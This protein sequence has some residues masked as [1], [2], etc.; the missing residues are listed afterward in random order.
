MK[1]KYFFA[2]IF[3]IILLPVFV[4]ALDENYCDNAV[5]EEYYQKY[6]GKPISYNLKYALGIKGN[7]GIYKHEL[8]DY[9]AKTT[10]GGACNTPFYGQGRA[11]GDRVVVNMPTFLILINNRVLFDALVTEGGYG[12]L[13]DN[14]I[15][16]I[17]KDRGNDEYLTP[18][19]LAVREGQVGTLKYLI[20]KYQVNLF[21]LSGNLY[22][23]PRKPKDA[24]RD[25]K[26]LMEISMERYKEQ[27]NYAKIECMLAVQKVVDQWLKKN[28]NN[29]KYLDDAE[30]YNKIVKEWVP[31]NIVADVAPFEFVPGYSPSL[32][33]FKLQSIVEESFAQNIE[34]QIDALME[35]IMRDFDISALGNPA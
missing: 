15:Y 22:R 10:K 3:A 35:K 24:P 31:K 30:R 5:Y 14:G 12:Y 21:K 8:L 20:D 23:S 25:V 7:R 4:Y 28:A 34:K 11:V 33:L 13:I 16:E 2:L 26:R 18:A 27:G 17:E 29:K 1:I 32:E 19:L 6:N 9:C